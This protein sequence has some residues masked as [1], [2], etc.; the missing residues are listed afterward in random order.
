MRHTISECEKFAQ[1]DYKRRHDN[2]AKR[3]HWELCKEHAS[4]R[5]ERWYDHIPDGTTENDD[6][7]LLSFI[8]IHCDLVVEARRPDI[9]ILD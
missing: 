3:I 7:E 8:N 9:V 5:K 1:K 4:E 6:I 2:V